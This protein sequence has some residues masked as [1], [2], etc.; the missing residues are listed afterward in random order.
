MAK[1]KLNKVELKWSKK[2]KCW[3]VEQGWHLW[4]YTTKEA[5]MYQARSVAQTSQPS[6]LIIR[7]KNGQFQE[8]RTYPRSRDPKRSRG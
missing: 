7:K 3:V 2:E 6:S 5:A 8:E 4:P 1:T